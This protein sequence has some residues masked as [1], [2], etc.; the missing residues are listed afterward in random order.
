LTLLVALQLSAAAAT[1]EVNDT[2]TLVRAINAANNDDDSSGSCPPGGSGTDV[3]ELTA[4]VELTAIHNDTAG[5]NGL[6]VVL[7]RIEIAGGG[8][9]ISRDPSAPDF[10]L[11]FVD[12][13]SG[14]LALDNV[15][16]KG[17]VATGGFFRIAGGAIHADYSSIE[18]TESALEGNS[19]E[20]GGAIYALSTDVSLLNSTVSG[21]SAS[22]NGGGFAGNYYGDLV[23][24]NSTISG[25]SAGSLGGGIWNGK[26]FDVVLFSSTVAANTASFGGGLSDYGS[27]F[28]TQADIFDSIVGYNAGGDCGTY[29]FP[30]S[31]D[32]FD[33]DGSCGFSNPLQGL[34]PSLADNG[35]PTR[36]HALLANAAPMDG[37]GDCGLTEDQRGLPRS[38][39]A[40]DSG[41]FEFGAAPVGGSTFGHRVQRVTCRNVTTGQTVSVQQPSGAWDCEAAGLVVSPG[42]RIRQ[43]VAGLSGDSSLGGTSIALSQLQASCQNATTG[44]QVRF[45]PTDTLTWSCLDQGLAYQMDDRVIQVFDGVV[46]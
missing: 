28:T 46:D 40:C 10:R 6:P 15:T 24:T 33:S 2:C 43:K 41:S 23:A 38:D 4:D 45:A 3:L 25:N 20:R 44:Q 39:G 22:E 13:P 9:E 1:I 21:N 11:F 27:F 35:G 5:A 7:S 31:N 30:I 42:D 8:F 26:S 19:A 34:D 37:A 17:G 16:L 32:S 12:G 36:T 29:D 18:L 14:T